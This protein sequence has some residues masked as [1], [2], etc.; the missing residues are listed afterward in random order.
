MV[1]FLQIGDDDLDVVLLVAIEF[2]KRIDARELA[3]G[4]HQLVALVRDPRGDRLVV[5]LAAA[6]ERGAEI[7]VFRLPAP[8]G[9]A[10]S[11]GRAALFNAPGESGF[12]G[13]SVSG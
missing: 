5:T 1:R 10:T 13:L 8:S 11:R 2:L 6:N 9:V 3:V 4:P 12:T 7:K